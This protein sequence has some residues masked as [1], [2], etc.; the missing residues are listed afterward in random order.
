MWT[1][2][3]VFDADLAPV[4]LGVDPGGLEADM[5]D[6]GSVENHRSPNLMSD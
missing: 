3:A 4:V 5:S 2:A 1:E 6:P